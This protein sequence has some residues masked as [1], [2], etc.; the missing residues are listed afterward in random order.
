MKDTLYHRICGNLRGSA[1]IAWFVLV[2]IFGWPLVLLSEV[3][4]KVRA[5]FYWSFFSIFENFIGDYFYFYYSSLLEELH[6]IRQKKGEP[7]TIVEIGPGP[8]ANFAYYP[9]DSNIIL[10]ERNEKFM[11]FIKEN[12]EKYPKMKLV[13]VIIAD[14]TTLTPDDIADNSADIVVGTHIFCCIQNDLASGH[15]I[16]R[17][18]RPGGK[19][20]SLEIVQR[21][22]RTQGYVERVQRALFRPFYRFLAMGCRLGT[23]LPQSN[24]LKDLGF[25]VSSMKTINCP[26]LPTYFSTT[27]YGVAINS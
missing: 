25:D 16:K 19:F 18:L 4:L 14:V 5:K 2:A 12:L 8:W 22:P 27:N 20:Y 21:D 13:K 7:L 15:Q 26:C 17:I 9:S 24:F 1:V 10:I 23:Q 11:P 6:Q 3:S